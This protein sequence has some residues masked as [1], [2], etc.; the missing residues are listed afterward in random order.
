MH[1]LFWQ[2]RFCIEFC[3]FTRDT[4][5]P[6]TM[7]V[8]LITLHTYLLLLLHLPIF[9]TYAR[10][11]NCFV[12]SFTRVQVT[13]DMHIITTQRRSPFWAELATR[14]SCILMLN[15]VMGH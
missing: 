12:F 15:L 7:T 13:T 5:I 6:F 8:Y 14:P 1:L 2:P 4:P 3:H 9:S 11:N 10:M